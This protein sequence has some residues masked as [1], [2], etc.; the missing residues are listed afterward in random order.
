MFCQAEKKLSPDSERK[1]DRQLADGLGGKKQQT[2]V[3]KR[4]SSKFSPKLDEIKEENKRV[5]RMTRDIQPS[6]DSGIVTRSGSSHSND[7]QEDSDTDTDL[8]DTEDPAVTTDTDEEFLSKND[9]KMFGKN[10]TKKAPAL[11]VSVESDILSDIY[12][13]AF[14]KVPKVLPSDTDSIYSLSSTIDKDFDYDSLDQKMTNNVRHIYRNPNIVKKSSNLPAKTKIEKEDSYE[15][16][17]MNKDVPKAKHVPGLY[18][19]NDY[20][21]NTNDN[22]ETEDNEYEEKNGPDDKDDQLI[23]SSEEK[24]MISI[25]GNSESVFSNKLRIEVNA[26]SDKLDHGNSL[27]GQSGGT[28]V[29]GGKLSNSQQKVWTNFAGNN[30]TNFAGKFHARVED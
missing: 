21:T 9:L 4:S 3:G 30:L 6:L 7:Q 20:N 19:N 12:S 24:M 16:I 15:E 1:E 23:Y 10:S 8:T 22:S 5:E 28:G 17:L 18:I 2:I 29:A 27:G 14:S 26:K 13:T 11:D 25:T